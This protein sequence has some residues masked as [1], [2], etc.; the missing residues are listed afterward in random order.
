MNWM[1]LLK[2]IGIV[3]AVLAPVLII[4]LGICL[5]IVNMLIITIPA[6]FIAGVVLI[7][8]ALNN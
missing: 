5:G 6:I 1:N 4:A 8:D 2:A 3:V 7:Y